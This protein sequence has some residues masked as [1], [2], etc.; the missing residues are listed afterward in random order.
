MR[1]KNYDSIESNDDI[2]TFIESDE[3]D[4]MDE[5][6]ETDSNMPSLVEY[7]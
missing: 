2:Q 6:M 4:E 7:R 1:K 5:I 3:H